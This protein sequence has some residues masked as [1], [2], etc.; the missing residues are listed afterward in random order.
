MREQL[1]GLDASIADLRVRLGTSSSQQ[2]Q[3]QPPASSSSSTTAYADLD[4]EKAARLISAR[5]KTIE[6]LEKRL[7]AAG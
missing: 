6:L 1:K 3:Q 7:A 5:T 2:Q 4:P